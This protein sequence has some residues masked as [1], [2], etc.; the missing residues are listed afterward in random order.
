MVFV[1]LITGCA[2]KMVCSPP[3]VLI[4]DVCC[5]DADENSVC[6]TWEEEEEPKIVSDK[7]K[8]SPEQE[9]M[10]GFAGTFAGTWDRKS[11]NALR[12][13]F[14]NDYGKRFSPQEFNFLA[15]RMDTALGIT[16]VELLGVDS[17][18]AEYSVR[19]GEGKTVVSAAIVS[20]EGTYRHRTFYFFEGL[21][22]DA[23]CE[24]DNECFVSFAKITGDRNYCDKAGE[25]KSECVAGFGV[26]KDLTAK[27][28]ECLEIFEYYSKAECLAQVAVK[29]NTVEPCWEAGFDKQIFECMGE[30]AAARNNV[31]ECSGFVASRGYPGT[32]L[33]TAYCITSY[34]R[35][36]GDTEACTKI[37]RRDDVVLGAMQEQCY[38]IIA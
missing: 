15:R 36:T 34:V 19:T 28:D 3:N 22:A 18:V 35:K 1:L 32:R 13:L 20:E 24:G 23:A 8:A 37:D 9:A 7:P 11:Y 25:L 33:Q 2:P 26:S 29:E 12:N 30:V 27:I 16:G 14:I 5:L 31:D 4:G 38:K 6:D 10:E 21:S 17:D